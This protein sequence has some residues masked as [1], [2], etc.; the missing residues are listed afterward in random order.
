VGAVEEDVAAADRQQLEPARPAGAGE[1]G[2]T[3]RRWTAGDAGALERIEDLIGNRRIGALMAPAEPDPG[4]SEPGR[5]TIVRASPDAPVTARS[6]RLM[7]AAFSRA[8]AA[9][10][11][12]SRSM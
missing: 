2:P 7:M 4:P 6:P 11:G 5:R 9:T 8:I 1:A 12:P 10:V 3:G